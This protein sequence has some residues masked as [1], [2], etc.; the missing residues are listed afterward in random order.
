MTSGEYGRVNLALVHG[1]GLGSLVWEGLR[2]PLANTF[3]VHLID[4]PGYGR[5]AADGADFEQTARNLLTAVPTPTVVCAWSLGATLAM[6]AALLDP[7]RVAGLILVGSTPRFTQGIDWPHAQTAELL[8]RFAAGVS[9]QAEPTL[10][11]FV[12]LLNQGDTR[13]KPITRT[14]LAALRTAA[15]PPV[16]TLQRGLDWLRGVDLRSDLP[17]ITSRCLL[18]H[19]ANDALNPLAAAY[20]LNANIA[21]SRL[22]VFA[23]T[24]HAPFL[25]DTRRFVQHVVDFCHG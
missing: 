20:Y 13:A 7:E 1:W 14:L 2:E 24:G 3:R 18:I 6:R 4:L 16:G 10:Q 22:E 21:D 9:A 15:M 19:G 11:R 17:A 12:S 5:T 25:A 8:D 23:D